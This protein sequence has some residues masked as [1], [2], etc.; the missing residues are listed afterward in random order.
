MVNKISNDTIRNYLEK[1]FYEFIENESPR[2]IA[3]A[4]T[5]YLEWLL[6][7][8]A[9]KR[10]IEPQDMIKILRKINLSHLI[11]LCYSTGT[12]NK[13]ERQDLKKINE[14]RNKFAHRWGIISFGHCEIKKRIQELN[15]LKRIGLNKEAIEKDLELSF[16]KALL[17]FGKTLKARIAK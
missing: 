8:L 14:I 7:Q 13:E 9:L 12:I 16:K 1:K 3:I 6:Y 17:L 5:C 11:D 2:G 15:I 10:L 4:G